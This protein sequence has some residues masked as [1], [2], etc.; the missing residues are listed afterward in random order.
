MQ[1]DSAVTLPADATLST[2]PAGPG[3]TL[4]D[5]IS[6]WS[7]ISVGSV[8]QSTTAAKADI[9][10]VVTLLTQPTRAGDPTSTLN[11]A[12]ASLACA[13]EDNQ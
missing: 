7:S 2:I 8:N 1:E 9:P 5:Y 11:V 12:V 3:R 6:S 13:A 10:A 4:A